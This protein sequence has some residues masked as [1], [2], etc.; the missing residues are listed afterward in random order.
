VKQVAYGIW[1]VG[2]AFVCAAS[3]AAGAQQK[4]AAD[5][6]TI[7]NPVAS[8]EDSLKAGRQLFAKYCATCH[9]KTGAGDGG[10]A[11]EGT[12]P[13]NFTDD[14]WNHGS[15]D[16]EIFVAIRDGI[17]PDFNMAGFESKLT[18]QQMWNLVN[19]VKSLSASKPQ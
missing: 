5:P 4:T 17:G 9:G 11:L 2:V 3:I 16:G 19:F 8:T 13:A 14:V 7:E 12:K 18:P 1:G 6:K 10:M 15:T